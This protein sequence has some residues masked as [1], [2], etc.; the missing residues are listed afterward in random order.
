MAETKQTDY[1]A[2][3]EDENLQVDIYTCIYGHNVAL[4]LNPIPASYITSCIWK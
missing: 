3:D 2:V 4:V 1:N